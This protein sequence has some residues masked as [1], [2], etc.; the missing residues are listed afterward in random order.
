MQK[1]RKTELEEYKKLNI[2]HRRQPRHSELSRLEF[3]YL[4]GVID[5]RQPFG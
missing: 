5:G 4:V 3:D 1:K 2:V